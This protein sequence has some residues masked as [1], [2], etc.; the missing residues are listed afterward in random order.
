MKIDVAES[1]R[2]PISRL[3]QLSHF[4]WVELEDAAG[5]A[6]GVQESPF[7]ATHSSDALSKVACDFPT[8]H[9][10]E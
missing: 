4:G 10:V 6:A 3:A 1:H 5:I 7:C 8:G 9:G 2:T